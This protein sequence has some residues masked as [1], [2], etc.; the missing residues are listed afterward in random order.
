MKT[1]KDEAFVL[2]SHKL[3]EAD[4]IITLLTRENGKKRA[5][6]KGLRRTK[7]KFGGRLEPG[8]HLAMELYRGRNLDI[9]T[10]AEIVNPHS[11]LREDYRKF[12]FGQAMLEMMEKS[13]HDDQ[14]VTN[15]FAALSTSL[16]ALGEEVFSYELLLAAF[17]LKICAL[18]G[19]RPHL[20]RCV[21]CGAEA[22]PGSVRLQLADG[23]ISCRSCPGSEGSALLD[24]DLL[25]LMRRAFAGTMADISKMQVQQ[26]LARRLMHLSFSYSEY[27]LDRRIKSHRMLESWEGGIGGPPQGSGQTAS[28]A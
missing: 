3:G 17:E 23:G 14:H 8:T 27:H 2:R 16:D 11:R 6:A 10:G 28:P 1:Y 25:Q 7:S 22:G 18:I 19:Y 5:V 21:C 26:G 13:V 15:A 9:I 4:K 12:L 24:P 20:D